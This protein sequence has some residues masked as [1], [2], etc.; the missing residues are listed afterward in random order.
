LRQTDA[1]MNRGF[2]IGVYPGLTAP[3][4]EYVASEVRNFVRGVR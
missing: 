3:M 2:W 4:R 1:V